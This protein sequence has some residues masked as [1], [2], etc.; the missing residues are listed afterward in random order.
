[1]SGEVMTKEIAAKEL[2]R[3]CEIVGETPREGDRET[4]IAAIQAGRLRFDE[5]SDEF[6]Y[7]LA[8]PVDRG[9]GEQLKE[10]RLHEPNAAE[11]ER[12][13][14]GVM[15][16]VTDKGTEIDSSNGIKKIQNA[17]FALGGVE[18]GFSDRIKNR[19]ISV[20]SA[21]IGFFG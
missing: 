14:R 2:D 1:M 8:K 6:V 20:L 12:I 18:I 15:M 3:I 11:T 5:K 17:L 21:I 7:T 13:N 16:I 9:S 10:I 19:D 4:L